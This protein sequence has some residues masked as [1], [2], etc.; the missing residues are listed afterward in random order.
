LRE[1][2][3]FLPSLLATGLG[4]AGHAFTKA[5]SRVAWAYASRRYTFTEADAERSRERIVAGLDRIES[6]RAGGDHLVGEELTVADITAASL[7]Y[8]LAWPDELQY[9]PPRPAQWK[10][11]ESLAGHQAVGWIAETYRRHRGVSA[12]VAA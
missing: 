1:V 2:D 5:T 3:G 12:E 4:D 7:L 6:E 9:S 11:G 10:F 8:P